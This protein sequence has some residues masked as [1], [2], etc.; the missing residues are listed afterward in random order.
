MTTP[1]APAQPQPCCCAA[2]HL[3][4]REITVLCV[5]ATGATSGEAAATLTLSRR[6]VDAHVASM[7]RKAGVRNRANSLQSSS[8]THRH[9][10]R[11]ASLVRPLLPA[12]RKHRMTAESS[13]CSLALVRQAR[14]LRCP[15]P[16]WS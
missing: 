9:G 4:E 16:R 3:T 15:R 12:H 1:T 14:R 2:S 7:L 13:C 6:T 8:R 11:H 10:G 5:L